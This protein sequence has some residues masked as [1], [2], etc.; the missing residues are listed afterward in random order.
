[1]T[2]PKTKKGRPTASTLDQVKDKVGSTLATVRERGEDVVADTREKAY[3]A[4]NE[5]NRMFQEHPIA[6]V[7]AAAAAGAVIAIFLPKLAI[8]SAADKAG[9]AAQRAVRNS[10]VR[11]AAQTMFANLAKTEKAALQTAAVEAARL[12]GKRIKKPRSDKKSDA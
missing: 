5:T 1:M 4:A 11:Q 10:G 3:R 12:I 2:A 8:G 9:R 7:A 6:A